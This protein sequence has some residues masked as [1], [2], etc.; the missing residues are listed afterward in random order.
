MLASPFLASSLLAFP[1]LDSLLLASLLLGSEEAC[2]NL[3][4]IYIQ[5]LKTSIK[6]KLKK[7]SMLKFTKNILKLFVKMKIAEHFR[8]L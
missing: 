1:L 6:G 2:W 8:T 3:L 5:N 4:Q 7:R